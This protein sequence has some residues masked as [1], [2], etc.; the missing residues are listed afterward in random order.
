MVAVAVHGV[1]GP[2]GRLSCLVAP[3][4]P[5]SG[6]TGP[7]TARHLCWASPT[8]ARGQE[9]SWVDLGLTDRRA[10]VGGGASGIGAG[11]AAVWLAEGARVVLAG[12]TPTELETEAAALGG[13]FVV[14]DLCTPDGPASGG[15]LGG[16][17]ARWAGPARRQLRRPTRGHLRRHR[18][19]RVG[20]GH[21]RHPA[22]D[23]AAHPRR[24]AAPPRRGRPGHRHQPLH[25]QCASRSPG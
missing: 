5:G 14:A 3:R 6:S 16:R 24:A 21:R 23:P 7:P 17:P 1:L 8:A 4:R 13:S 18:R 12:R 25:R 11:I 2:A 15:R 22:V 19:G 9:E 10:L 20:T